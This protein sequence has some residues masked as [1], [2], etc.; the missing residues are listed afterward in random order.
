MINKIFNQNIILQKIKPGSL[1][2]NDLTDYTKFHISSLLIDLGYDLEIVLKFLSI[3][4]DTYL[5]VLKVYDTSNMWYTSNIHMGALSIISKS[6]NE[7]S[8]KLATK[9]IEE[10]DRTKFS[11]T[12]WRYRGSINRVASFYHYVPFIDRHDIK[13]SE[14]TLSILYEDL[15]YMQNSLGS[16]TYPNGF[17]CIELDSVVVLAFLKKKGYDVTKMLELKLFNSQCTLKKNGWS[18][19][20]KGQNKFVSFLE[21]FTNV[22]S[23]Q[24]FLWNTKKYFLMLKSFNMIMAIKV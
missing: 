6:E 22:S 4:M 14:K 11:S 24:D 8:I 1:F 5:N 16:F 9:M 17:S 12:K 15:T 23:I 21:L 2:I 10:L 3:N 18:L 20:S 19:F 13:I 7:N